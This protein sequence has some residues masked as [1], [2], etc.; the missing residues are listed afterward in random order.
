M[1][2]RLF[3]SVHALN[4]GGVETSL[5]GLLQ[6]LDYSRVDVDLFVF[7][8]TGELMGMIPKEVKLLPE[9]FEY[10]WVLT[11]Y[12]ECLK[13][14]YYKLAFAQFVKK[15]LFWLYVRIRHPKNF[16]ASY[17]YMG[18]VLCPFLPDIGNGTYD[19]ALSFLDPHNFIL[20]HVR[21]KQKLGW[22][23]TDYT[24]IDINKK[25]EGPIWGG[26]DKIV[27]VSDAVSEQFGA[28]FPQLKDKIITIE[29]VLS[30]RFIRARADE[31]FPQEYRALREREVPIL[32]SVGRICPPKNYENVPLMI[33]ELLN[34]GT[35]FHWFIV[36]PGGST[37][38][39]GKAK[40]LGVSDY[41]TFLGPRVNPYPYI[42]NCS[43]YV[44]PSIYEGKSV[45]VREAQ[46]LCKPVVITDYPTAASQVTDGVDGMV[47][48][49]DN[50]MIAKGIAEALRSPEKIDRIQSYLSS[51]NYGN[52]SEVEKI[53][54]M[55]D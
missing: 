50:K 10:K 7:S 4:I 19:L 44:H 28:V 23:H 13:A 18:W 32:C 52:E 47:V 51:H 5:I 21:A 53:Y 8:H 54:A 45:V 27:G 55:L 41:L 14:G 39:Q 43:L 1:K 25:L 26:L 2:K 24:K 15:V 12:V 37:A 30:P 34:M 17:S 31:Y 22:I 29:N 9:V 36:G 16:S 48:P 49:L 38:I 46:I 42:K 3:I 6:S 40:E 35:R 20:K 11:D 33:K